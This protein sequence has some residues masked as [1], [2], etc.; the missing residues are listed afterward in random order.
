MN[1]ERFHEYHQSGLIS[2]N[3]ALHTGA[4]TGFPG[5]EFL[6]QIPDPDSMW[7]TLRDPNEAVWRQSGLWIRIPDLDPDPR[8]AWDSDPR[9]RVKSPEP[10][11]N[12]L[13]SMTCYNII[14]FSLPVGNGI[15]MIT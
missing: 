5:S 3:G 7:S 1:E 4:E 9:S 6:I 2:R 14:I 11:F 15:F 13:I 8:F 10:F 12:F